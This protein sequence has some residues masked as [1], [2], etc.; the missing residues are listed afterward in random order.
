MDRNDF[1]REFKNLVVETVLE[2]GTAV[3]PTANEYGWKDD[4]ARCHIEG[5][6]TWRAQREGKPDPAPCKW[7][8]NEETTFKEENVYEFGDTFNGNE[9]I[10]INVSPVSCAC[11]ELKDRAIRYEGKTAEFIPLMFMDEKQFTPQY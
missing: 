3:S 8:P 10:F 2:H 5:R 11:G 9:G 4:D 1:K 6:N 7:V